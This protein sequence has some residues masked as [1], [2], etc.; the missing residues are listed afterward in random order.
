MKKRYYLLAA[1]VI[2]VV[3]GKLNSPSDTVEKTKPEK[4]EFVPTGIWFEGGT[5]HKATV[6]EWNAASPENKLAT[7]GDFMA[8]YD[9]TIGIGRKL[10]DRAGEL[11]FCVDEAVKALP[12]DSDEKVSTIAASCTI[13]MFNK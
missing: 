1:I 12:S 11:V 10:R 5:L 7:C 4:T 13:L 8:T 6:A 9:K 3:I 2:A